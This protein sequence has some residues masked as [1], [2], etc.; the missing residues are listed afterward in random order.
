VAVSRWVGHS[1]RARRLLGISAR[2]R[3]PRN[4]PLRVSVFPRGRAADPR[5]SP[6]APVRCAEGSPPG[7]TAIR[8][9][10]TAMSRSTH[11]SVFLLVT[12]MTFTESLVARFFSLLSVLRHKGERVG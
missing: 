7:T 12:L 2:S 1:G 4:I 6:V 5:Q 3:A 9:P 10:S 11:H 8:P